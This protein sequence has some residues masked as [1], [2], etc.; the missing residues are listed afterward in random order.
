MKWKANLQKAS[1]VQTDNNYTVLKQRLVKYL[2]IVESATVI[3]ISRKM[4]LALELESC[5]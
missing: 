5:M 1:F 4:V 3:K 2:G